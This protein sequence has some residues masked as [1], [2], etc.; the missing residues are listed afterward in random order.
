MNVMTLRS[1]LKLEQP[2][3]ENRPACGL[4]ENWNKL[5]KKIGLPSAR[6]GLLPSRLEL[7]RRH[8][9]QR[10]VW[11]PLIVI[12]SP[13]LD[14]LS[15]MHQRLEPVAEWPVTLRPAAA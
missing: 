14:F 9:P 10:G 5:S 13:A 6:S 8:P 4:P 1:P 15:R 12:Y 3:R 11:P 7:L 2:E